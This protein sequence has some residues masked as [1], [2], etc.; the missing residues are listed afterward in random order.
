MIQTTNQIYPELKRIF[1]DQKEEDLFKAIIANKGKV[2]I[3]FDNKRMVAVVNQWHMEGI[4]HHW[5]H[6]YGLKPRAYT[7]ENINP[8]GDMDLRSLLFERMYHGMMRDIKSSFSRAPPS[9][10]SNM[11]TPYYREGNAQFEH[12]NM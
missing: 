7:W 1:V 3:N 11:I 5:C 10:F 2:R 12:R 6:A 4:E 9:S 8:I